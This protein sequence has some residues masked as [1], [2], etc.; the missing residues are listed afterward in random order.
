MTPWVCATAQVTPHTARAPVCRAG[1][2]E[3]RSRCLSSNTDTTGSLAG[4][5]PPPRA[6]GPWEGPGPPAAPPCRTHM[7][8]SAFR[9]CK[10][11]QTGCHCGRPAPAPAPT[12]S[13]P[14][15]APAPAPTAGQ[16]AAEAPHSP[17]RH[18][19]PQPLQTRP[20]NGARPHCARAHPRAGSRL[21]LLGVR[22]A[23]H[24]CAGP[25]PHARE[26][27]RAGAA[28]DR[29]YSVCAAAAAVCLSCFSPQGPRR[30]RRGKTRCSARRERGKRNVRVAR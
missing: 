13:S 16:R 27:R 5:C 3:A 20:R 17:W 2:T 7:A 10:R 15:P 22:N 24:A 30:C 18:R 23:R 25:T 11:T 28:G 6:G 26:P 21:S 4:L 14:S 1:D 9:A 12:R 29:R 19:A 8:F